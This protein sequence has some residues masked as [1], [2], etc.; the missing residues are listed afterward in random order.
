MCI[1]ININ[2]YL[3]IYL[4]AIVGQHF[5]PKKCIL[6]LHRVSLKSKDII[7]T[8]NH[9]ETRSIRTAQ[10]CPVMFEK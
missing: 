6:V 8:P 4:M 7:T 1:Y 10:L 2:I 5:N 3:Y 9:F